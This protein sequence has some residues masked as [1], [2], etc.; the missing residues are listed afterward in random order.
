MQWHSLPQEIFKKKKEWKN[1]KIRI[2]ILSLVVLLP[3]WQMDIIHRI[4]DSSIKWQHD[5]KFKNLEL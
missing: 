5:N 3:D 1:G 4:T 2:C